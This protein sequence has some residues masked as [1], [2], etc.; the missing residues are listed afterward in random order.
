MQSLIHIDAQATSLFLLI[1]Y[2]LYKEVLTRIL[3]MIQD[4]K[5]GNGNG[6]GKLTG[7]FNIVEIRRE[8]VEANTLVFKPLMEN[9]TRILGEL[10]ESNREIAKGMI[11]LLERTG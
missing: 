8:I 11:Q 2:V 10:S 7:S 4:R 6:N 1:L 5:N 9:Q 3:V